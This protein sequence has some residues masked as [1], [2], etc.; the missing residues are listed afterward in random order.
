MKTIFDI[1]YEVIDNMIKE[2][3]KQYKECKEGRPTRMKNNDSKNW[4]MV[5]AEDR[6]EHYREVKKE[7]KQF[8]KRGG[9]D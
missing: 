6:I 8:V 1:I 7:I 9:G 5:N 3:K 4:G 2:Q